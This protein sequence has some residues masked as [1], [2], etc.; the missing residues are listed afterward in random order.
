MDILL[1]PFI[2]KK[3]RLNKLNRLSFLFK[4]TVKILQ[5]KILTTIIP[6]MGPIILI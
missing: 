5:K 2:I 3:K 6:F 4:F 1:S